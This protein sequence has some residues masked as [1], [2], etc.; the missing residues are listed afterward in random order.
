MTIEKGNTAKL[1][2]ALAAVLAALTY[3]GELVFRE[4]EPWAHQ[5]KLHP[6]PVL[7]ESPCAYI[8][9]APNRP[10]RAGDYDLNQQ[11]RIEV[12]FAVAGATDGIARRGDDN[13]LG[14]SKIRD[15]I[16][17]CL[18][19]YHPEGFDCDDF[20]FVDEIEYLDAPKFYAAGLVFQA[21][22]L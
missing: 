1:E 20:Y 11:L 13:H 5:I 10:T 3:D 19:E 2:D 21:A 8:A 15:L 12:V 14:A 4:A 18:D 22:Q 6:A 7:R 17:D 16:I 9:F